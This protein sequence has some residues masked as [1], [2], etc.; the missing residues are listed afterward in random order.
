MTSRAESGQDTA[1][2]RY[3]PPPPPPPPPHYHH[4]PA[5]SVFCP[6][7]KQKLSPFIIDLGKLVLPNLKQDIFVNDSRCCSAGNL[8]GVT[9]Y[10]PLCLQQAHTAAVPCPRC[11]DPSRPSPPA[12][13]SSTRPP[14]RGTGPQQVIALLQLSPRK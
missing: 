3:P 14:T 2:A 11:R 5:P 12:T 9:S 7:V 10:T 13:A 4:Q 8:S 1:A 6:E